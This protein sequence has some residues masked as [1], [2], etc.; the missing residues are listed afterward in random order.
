VKCAQVSGGKARVL[1]APRNLGGRP[2]REQSLRRA[3]AAAPTLSRAD[4]RALLSSLAA[5]ETIPSDL[6][7]TAL[8]A[9][10][11]APE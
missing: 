7:V 1:P 11:N 6:R 2:T 9:L 8:C 10:L 3:I 5:S 4:A